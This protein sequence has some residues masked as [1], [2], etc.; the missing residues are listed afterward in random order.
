MPSV[1]LEASLVGVGLLYQGSCHRR[2]TEAL[3]GEISKKP[4]DTIVN[5][6]SL[7][8]SAGLA[9]GFVLLGG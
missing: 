5:R 7:S 2:V 4:T 9:L 8:L 3:L 1:V 6:E